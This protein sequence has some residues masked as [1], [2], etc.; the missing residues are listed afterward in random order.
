MPVT[1]DDVRRIAALACIGIAEERVPALVAELDGILGHM[2]VLS[3]VSDIAAARPAAGMPLAPDD[4][5]SVP[6]TRALETLA[7]SMRDGFFLVPRLATHEE[8]AGPE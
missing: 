5:S 6:L 4:P 2:A 1:P 8:G 7:P 3:R